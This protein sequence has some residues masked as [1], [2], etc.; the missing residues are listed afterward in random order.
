MTASPDSLT[1]PD[2]QHLID[3]QREQGVSTE[4]LRVRVQ[5]K[6]RLLIDKGVGGNAPR[7][8]LDKSHTAGAV[9]LASMEQAANV[10]L[11]RHGHA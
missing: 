11:R 10:S 2:N 9:K 6:L 4:Y 1:S 7:Y 8:L 3:F 5:E